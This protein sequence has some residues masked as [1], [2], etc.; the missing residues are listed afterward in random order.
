[1]TKFEFSSRFLDNPP[2]MILL[3]YRGSGKTTIGRRLAE[4]LQM[5][6]IDTDDLITAMAD[7]SIREIF[8]QKGEA[9]FRDLESQAVHEVCGKDAIIALGGG[10]V[11][12]EQN[13]SRL[14]SS[15]H[16]RVYL[17]CGAQALHDRIHADPRTAATRPSL[18]HLGG[19][20]EE[21]RALLAIRE[22]LYR[23]VMTDELDV[24]SLSTAQA[25]GQL[26]KEEI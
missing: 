8:E 3:G 12:R 22:P 14:I 11:M 25:A 2:H 4:Q 20:I 23:W 18:T 6:F 1:M 13:R 17:R 26:A 16:R 24:T 5:P 10:A 21:I 19:G 7:R 9:Y 15:S